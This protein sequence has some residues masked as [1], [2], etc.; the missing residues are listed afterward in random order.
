MFYY[1]F[2]RT[3]IVIYI[4]VRLCIT[5]TQLHTHYIYMHS[6]LAFSISCRL[7]EFGCSSIA[8]DP[9]ASFRV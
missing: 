6:I 3:Y 5:Y 2:L 8:N 1:I 4:H 7:M 9:P